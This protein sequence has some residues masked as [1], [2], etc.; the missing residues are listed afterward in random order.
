MNN[1]PHKI[2]KNI[3]NIEAL[4]KQLSQWRK[5]SIEDLFQSVKEFEKTP[6]L[7]VSIYYNDLFN[8][9]NFSEI[10][11]EIYKS[12][13]DNAKMVILLISAIGN[14]IQRY[15]L[16]ESQDMYEFMVENAYKKN[17]GPYVAIFLPR[18]KYFKNYSKK[19]QYFMDVKEM[20][21]KKVAESSFEAL[22]DLHGHEIPEENKEEVVNYFNKKSEQSNNAY[23]R[24]HYLDLANRF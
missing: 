20:S 16:P 10:L 6:R 13:T 7:E 21:P 22:M 24:Q 2:Q 9:V 23:G 8:D 5:L 12:N 19:W 15:N 11:L 1:I 14:M 18:L 17:I 3:D 4:K